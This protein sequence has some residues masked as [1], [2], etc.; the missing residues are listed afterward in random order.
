MQKLVLSLSL[1]VASSYAISSDSHDCAAPS[2]YVM[3]FLKKSGTVWKGS[4]EW[5]NKL[6]HLKNNEQ[7]RTAYAATPFKEY[8]GLAATALQYVGL[9][10]TGVT[11][12]FEVTQKDTHIEVR[13]QI[14]QHELRTVKDEAELNNLKDFI[15]KNPQGKKEVQEDRYSECAYHMQILLE[16]DSK[17]H[18][19]SQARCKSKF[20]FSQFKQE[21][22][23]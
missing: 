22:D 12:S 4:L 14:E 16:K 17:V 5:K 2:E 3:Q 9:R 8:Y 11:S 19:I 1:L 15:N 6:Y 23:K 18:A 7:L 13:S 10:E 20:P 21:L